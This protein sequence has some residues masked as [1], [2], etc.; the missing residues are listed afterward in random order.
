MFLRFYPHETENRAELL[1]NKILAS[2]K[3]VSAA[4]LQGYFMIFKTDSEA[5]LNNIEQIW[6]L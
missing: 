4:Q 1:C 2:G 6:N 5:I 3:N